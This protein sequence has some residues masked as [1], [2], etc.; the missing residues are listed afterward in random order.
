SNLQR[1]LGTL[2]IEQTGVVGNQ[3]HG[4]PQVR[5]TFAETAISYRRKIDNLPIWLRGSLHLRFRDRDASYGGEGMIFASI[6]PIQ[7]RVFSHVQAYTQSVEGNQE[8]SLA[9][10]S[11]LERSF[12]LG[13]HVFLLPRFAFLGAYQ[14]LAARPLLS[15]GAAN[16]AGAAGMP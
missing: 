14:S 6:N 12:P 11:Y 1:A 13:R 10:H 16:A 9:L 2:R 15:P 7:L 3:S 8:Y 5:D 4:D